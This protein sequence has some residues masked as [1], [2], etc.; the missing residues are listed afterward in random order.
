MEV[1]Q[2]KKIVH[3]YLENPERSHR[4]IAKDLNIAPSTVWYVI[5]RYRATLSVDRKGRSS[6]NPPGRDP[7]IEIKIVMDI[8]KTLT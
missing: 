6:M 7:S 2:R 8:K 4:K 5:E 3:K 1:E